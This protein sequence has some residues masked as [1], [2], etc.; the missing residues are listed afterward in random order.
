MNTTD[1]DLVEAAIRYLAKHRKRQP[2]LAELAAHIGLSQSH[3]HRLFSRWAGVTPKRFLEFLTVQHAKKLL[4]NSKSVL[5]AAHGS[6][7]TGP[8]R[9]HDHFVTVEAVTPG[10]YRSRGAGLTIRFGTGESPFG[11]VFVAWTERGLCRVGFLVDGDIAAEKEA[12]R[13]A[14]GRASLEGDESMSTA[15]ARSIF[16]APYEAERRPPD[17]PCA[18]DQLPTGRLARPAARTSRPGRHLRSS[19]RSPRQCAGGSGDR[20]RGGQESDRLP[21]PVPPRDSARRGSSATTPGASPGNTAC[22]RGRRVANPTAAPR[23]GTGPRRRAARAT[24][25]A[26]TSSTPSEPPTPVLA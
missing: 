3:L 5:A 25:P 15:L 18:R 11:P 22:W 6:G 19:G 23:R 24:I 7:L 1:Y 9:L 10:E 12:L 14:W 13:R 17:R 8:G 4:D 20:E 16:S 2:E 21:H 26:R